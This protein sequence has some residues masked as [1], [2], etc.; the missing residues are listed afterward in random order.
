MN[1]HIKLLR[2]LTQ[3]MGDLQHQRNSVTGKLGRFYPN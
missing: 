3:K 1:Q 2:A